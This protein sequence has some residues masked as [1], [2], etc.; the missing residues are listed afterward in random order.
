MLG[1]F[2]T[3]AVATV[4]AAS[5]GQLVPALARWQPGVLLATFG[6][7]AV[8][9]MQ[10]VALAARLNAGPPWPSWRLCCS[11]ASAGCS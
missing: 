9:N 10:G 5:V 6:F 1:V 3:A 11:S 8:V 4:F 2:A 7:W